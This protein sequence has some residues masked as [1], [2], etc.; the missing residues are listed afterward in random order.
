MISIKDLTI[1]NYNINL[2]IDENAKLG[3]FARNTS[4][5][6]ELLLIIAGINRSKNNCFFDD[7]EIYDNSEYFKKRI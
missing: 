6:K 7:K 4:L 5:I 3:I 1:Q 2:E